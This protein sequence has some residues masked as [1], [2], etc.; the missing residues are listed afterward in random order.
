MFKYRRVN[1]ERHQ[2]CGGISVVRT[3]KCDY[4]ICKK[5]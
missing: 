1:D 3:P 4:I 2:R 5:E